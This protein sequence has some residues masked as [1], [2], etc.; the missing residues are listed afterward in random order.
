LGLLHQLANSAN[1][2][3]TSVSGPHDVFIVFGGKVFQSR[4]IIGAVFRHQV[5]QVQNIA[6]ID[7]GV[8]AARVARIGMGDHVGQVAGGEQ[9]VVSGGFIARSGVL[10]FNVDVGLFLQLLEEGGLVHVV[11]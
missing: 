11:H 1:A 5:G 2:A 9:Q 3:A 10:E 7:T 4:H 8:Q 6:V